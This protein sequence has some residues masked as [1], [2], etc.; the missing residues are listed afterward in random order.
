VA[1]TNRIEGVP[2]TSAVERYRAT[3]LRPAVWMTSVLVWATVVAL[4]L[5]VPTWASVFLCAVSGTSFAFYLVCYIYL[6]ARDREVLR[7]ERYRVRA[8][9]GA[10]RVEASRTPALPGEQGGPM[11]IG[12]DSVGSVSGGGHEAAEQM[13]GGEARRTL[14]G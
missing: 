2:E 12:P 1:R 10:A 3:P 14:G 11:Y 7:A 6:M 9:A 8:G 5:R 4:I 13:T